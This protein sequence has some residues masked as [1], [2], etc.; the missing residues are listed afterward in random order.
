MS[1]DVPVAPPRVFISYSHSD[2]G[3]L[4]RL[5]VH[6]GPLARDG[7]ITIWDDS[8][9]RAGDVWR[10]EI[11]RGLGG[12][13]AAILLVSA[14]FLNSGFIH[15]H[16]L[17]PIFDAFE[18]RGVRIYWVLLSPCNH[19]RYPSLSRLQAVNPGL[20]PLEGQ[21]RPKR[22]AVWAGLAE[23]VAR[24]AQRCGAAMAGSSSP[25]PGAA[26]SAAA[27]AVAGPD[28]AEDRFYIERETDR[29]L[30]DALEA[31]P[32]QTAILKG[33]GKSGKSSLL[34]RLHRWAGARGWA[35]TVVDFRR[36]DRAT[37]DDTTSLFIAVARVAAD[38]LGLEL[39]PAE[40]WSA[41]LGPKENLTRFLVRQVLARD[42][43]PLLLLLDDADLL[44]PH[45][46]C[47]DDFFSILRVWH[48][49]RAFDRAR[50]S[51]VGMVV[52]H[53]VDPD[54]W[55]R[56]RNQ[57]PFNVGLPVVLEGFTEAEVA[58]LNRLHGG[59]L[60]AGAVRRLCG[61]VG[62]HPF[63]VRQAFHWM[64]RRGWSFARIEAEALS[65]DGPFAPH[66]RGLFRRVAADSD[67]RA[68]FRRIRDDHAC[69][70]AMYQSLWAAGLIRGRSREQVE[71]RARIYVDYFRDVGV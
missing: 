44:F 48:N 39:D 64:V 1:A 67:I 32:G 9:I 21:P 70:E 45:P 20:K 33:H 55:I 8:R 13:A 12:I 7:L 56:D 68:A 5:K 28:P 60:D 11:D 41:R 4:E 15:E 57:S 18:R 61:L 58:E 62:G 46:A 65:P 17:P 63:L 51:R 54:D 37:Y 10:D 14:D 43:R 71:F 40:S 42:P 3:A 30:L 31:D 6:L 52:A 53:S 25:A 49:E 27:T 34:A 66:L 23:A 50:W 26:P 47:C 35:S 22:E 36:I 19:D 38:R 59:L 69:D 16:E 29:S 2:R 24:D